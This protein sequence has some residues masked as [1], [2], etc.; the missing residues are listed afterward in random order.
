MTAGYLGENVKPRE[1]QLM[2][3]VCNCGHV[4][5]KRGEVENHLHFKMV[6]RATTCFPRFFGF[7]VRKYMGWTQKDMCLVEKVTCK[8]LSQRPIHTFKGLLGYW[9][10]AFCLCYI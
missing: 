2:R 7:I 10:E 3:D 5:M 6:V 9:N 1:T 4:A 8:V